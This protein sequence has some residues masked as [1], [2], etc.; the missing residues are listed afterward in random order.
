MTE[1]IPVKAQKTDGPQGL[2]AMLRVSVTSLFTGSLCLQLFLGSF[3]GASEHLG[4][5]TMFVSR[6]TIPA[7]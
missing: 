5:G 1:L 4:V 3:T 2:T 7:Q 6:L